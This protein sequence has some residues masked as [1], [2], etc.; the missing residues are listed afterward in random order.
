VKYGPNKGI[1]IKD[2]SVRIQ[3]T[4]N[5]HDLGSIGA[6]S[7]VRAAECQLEILQEMGS[8]A[9]RTS[10]NPPAP[11]YLE[12]ADRM[13]ML[14]LYEIFDCWN[15]QKRTN[16]FHQ[17]FTDWKE[18]D[19]RLFI[20]RDRNHPSVIASSIGNEVEE[21][22]RANIG[23]TAQPLHDI[24]K[25]EDPTRPINDI[26]ERGFGGRCH[27]RCHGY[28]EPKLPWRGHGKWQHEVRVPGLPQHVP[29]Q[30][31]SE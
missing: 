31:A 26:V 30:N 11:E 10:H 24:A 6:A 23:A 21:Q 18:A 5:H 22:G 9:L 8:N 1:L 4:N 28:R 7:N 16:D 3:G 19:L 2:Q 25:S 17:I 15:E 20:R 27:S 14:V 12:L 13:G 29:R